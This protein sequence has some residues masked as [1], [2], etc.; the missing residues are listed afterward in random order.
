MRGWWHLIVENIDSDSYMELNDTDREHIAK[1][2][3]EGYNQ[4]EIIH[5]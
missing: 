4:G 5:D 2:I 3:K 1:L